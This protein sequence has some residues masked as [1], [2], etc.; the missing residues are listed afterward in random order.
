MHL[1]CVV[2]NC[3]F[4]SI[5]CWLFFYGGMSS[6]IL[7]YHFSTQHKSQK[8]NFVGKRN[9]L[10]HKR[11]CLSQP[12]IPALPTSYVDPFTVG[13]I[14]NPRFH[15]WCGSERNKNTVTGPLIWNILNILKDSYLHHLQ[16]SGVDFSEPPE[17]DKKHIIYC[18]YFIA[19]MDMFLGSK[20]WWKCWSTLLF[21]SLPFVWA[22]GK[23]RT[24]W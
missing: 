7:F 4:L 3:F 1:E 8:F 10:M 15:L 20:A 9:Q 19:G 16:W 14:P 23:D 24:R 22:W 21:L 5:Y 17:R 11:R 2:D 18:L 12:P 6:E 13:K